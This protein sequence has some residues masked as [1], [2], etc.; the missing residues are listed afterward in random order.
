MS[1]PTTLA[2]TPRFHEKREALLS[3]AAQ[4]FNLLGVR[5]AT[6]AGIGAQV[7]LATNSVTYYYRKKEDLALACNLRSIAAIDDWLADAARQPTVAQRVQRFFALQSEHLGRIEAA[8]QP[9]LVHFNDIRALP[10]PK[11]DQVFAA[12]TDMFRHLRALVS[13]PETA[14]LSRPALNARAHLLLSVS[15]WMRAW[16]V[17]HEADEYPRVARRVADILLHGVAA[18]GAAWQ[19]A[20]AADLRWNLARGGDTDP[21][22]P[23][24]AFLRAATTLVNEQ[25]YRGASVAKIS[26]RLN[27]TKGSFYHHHDKKRDLISACFE[28]S[29]DVM[30]RAFRLAEDS[31]GRGFDRAC[32]AARALVRFQC[33]DQ[34]PLLRSTATSAVPDPDQR[35]R[36]RR[37]MDQLTER[38]GCVLVDALVDGSVRPLDSHIAAQGLVAMIN[39]AAEL[40]RWVP[41]VDSDS[42][43]GLYVRPAFLGLLCEP[44]SGA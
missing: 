1:T 38:M 27:V 11:V 15:H 37:T 29:F 25:G 18:P 21:S 13:G 5:G 31:P 3:A 40:Q 4:Q 6:L 7:G 23:G 41:G 10:S 39:A 19:A 16:I 32:A 14:G 20:D 43:M 34:G 28:R 33:S 8:E 2:P 42:A 12:Y 44:E 26:A 30:R 36:V 22:G 35:Q 9:Q 24:D 17:R